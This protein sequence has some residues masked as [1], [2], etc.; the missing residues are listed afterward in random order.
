VV[1]EID[2]A[3]DAFIGLFHGRNLGKMVVKLA[4]PTLLSTIH[5]GVVGD[6]G[7]EPPTHSV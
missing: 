7:F 1:E 5:A 4:E 2:R 6:E 3:V